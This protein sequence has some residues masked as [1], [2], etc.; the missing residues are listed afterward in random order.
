MFRKVASGASPAASDAAEKI[1]EPDR[2]HGPA[3]EAV[4]ERPGGQDDR[5]ERE[6]VRVDH[7]LQVGE[8]RRQVLLIAGSAVF[9]TVMSSSS[10]NVATLTA[11]RVHHFLAIRFL[12]FRC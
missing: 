8:A 11:S 1:A 6:R 4:G 9:T 7:P 2:E 12:R 3:A 10:M 5:R